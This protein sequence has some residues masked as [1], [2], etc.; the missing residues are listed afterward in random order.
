M[1]PKEVE[2]YKA[3]VMMVLSSHV[4]RGRAIGMADLYTEVYGKSPRSRITGTRRLRKL[5]TGLR[6]RGVPICSVADA[7]GGGYYIP[8]AGSEMEAHLKRLRN[9]GLKKLVQEAHLRK[10]SLP[11]LLGQISLNLEG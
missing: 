7:E 3:K 11:E 8:A 1:N 9:Q 4:G 6:N 2:Q 10:I 5:I